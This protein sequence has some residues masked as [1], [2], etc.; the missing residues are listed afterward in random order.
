MKIKTFARSSWEVILETFRGFSKDKVTKLSGALA[1]Y[2][3]FSMG[4]LLVVII[5]LCGLI[6]EA[7]MVEGEVYRI[8]ED[9]LGADTAAQLEQVI[10]N[11]ALTDKN[12]LAAIVGAVTLFIGATTVFAVIQDAINTIWGLKPEPKRGWLRI[13]INR[14]LSFSVIVSLGF[15]LLVS[16]TVTGLIEGLSSRLRAMFP[17]V[18]VGLFYILNLLIT[19]LVS[20]AIFA[21][22][23]KV[24]PDAKIR[25]KD[26]MTGAFVTACLFLLGKFGISFYV[27]QSNIGSTYGA[28]GSIVVLLVWVYYSSII[29]YLGAEFTKAYTRQY[30]QRIRPADYAVKVESVE[31]EVP[32][33]EQ[34][35]KPATGT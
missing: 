30:G 3:V 17:D 29:L 22:I 9:F 32:D 12:T 34:Q 20:T 4:P 25:W 24:L 19:L 35:G 26:V 21:M 31:T 1:Y 23:F 11:A 33:R 15:L 27:A 16:L 7:E 2:T 13:I 8:L 18:A 28:A 6:I 10:R 14:F 5:S